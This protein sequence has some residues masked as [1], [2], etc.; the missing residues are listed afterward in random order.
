MRNQSDEI[1]CVCPGP[2]YVVCNI[3]IECEA[4]PHVLSSATSIN[5]HIIYRIVYG[6]KGSCHSNAQQQKTNAQGSI[7]Y[8]SINGKQ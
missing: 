3:A 1:H 7:I 8:P 6:D 2:E 5:G 4:K